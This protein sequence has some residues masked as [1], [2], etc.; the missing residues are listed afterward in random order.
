MPEVEIVRKQIIVVGEIGQN[1]YGDLTWTDKDNNPYKVKSTRKQYF[2]CIVP[3]QAV[4]ISFSKYKGTEYPYS[5]TPVKD[6]LSEKPQQPPQSKSSPVAVVGG[7][8]VMAK[9][10]WA[11]KDK[12]TRKSIERQ[13]SLNAAVEVA[14]LIGGDKI[15]TEKIIATAKVFEAY[16]GGQTEKT[17]DKEVRPAVKKGRLVEETI[18]M[19]AVEED[20]P[21]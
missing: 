3:G 1:T 14:K 10:D 19:G 8:E 4:E 2:E 12:I 5:A 13:T 16:L 20:I 11:E 18:K 15:T 21:Y 17:Q 7:S 9:G 6:K